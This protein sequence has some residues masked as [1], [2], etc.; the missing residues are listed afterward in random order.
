MKLRHTII[1]IAA[2]CVLTAVGCTPSAEIEIVHAP[3]T[4]QPVDTTTVPMPTAEPT[5]TLE[6]TSKPTP[7]PTAVPTP[8]PTPA[9]TIESMVVVSQT[10]A[11]TNEYIEVSIVYPEI[12]GMQD[13]AVQSEINNSV[14]VKLDTLAKSIEESSMNDTDDYGEHDK[15]FAGAGFDV[16]RNDGTVLSVA[17]DIYTFEGGAHSNTDSAFITVFNTNPA[18]RPALGDLFIDGTDYTTLIN[19][20]INRMI[21]SNP[22]A[23][24]FTFWSITADQWYYLTDT[25]LVIV[26]PAFEIAPGAY[27]EPEFAIPLDSLSNTLVPQLS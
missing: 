18:Q 9:P 19:D 23:D 26:F 16:M 11:F 27:G 8:K 21:A 7:E 25:Q 2:L 4:S 13:T 20:E 6:P 14:L 17:L 5:A 10:L 1:L 15:F 24:M 12:S 3:Q 22:E